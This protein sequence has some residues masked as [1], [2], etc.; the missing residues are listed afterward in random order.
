M[1]YSI[2]RR[3]VTVLDVDLLLQQRD[4]LKWVMGDGIVLCC[5]MLSLSA[6]A[7]KVTLLDA[8]IGAMCNADADADTNT[9]AD[10][11]ADIRWCK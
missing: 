1:R 4:L 9:D 7:S 5:H 10:A 2:I 8:A 6:D 11:D 3:V